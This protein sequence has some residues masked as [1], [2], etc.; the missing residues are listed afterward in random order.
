MS[1]IFFIVSKCV[2]KSILFYVIGNEK[3]NQKFKTVHHL[4]YTKT[5]LGAGPNGETVIFEVDNKNEAFA[6]QL[7]QRYEQS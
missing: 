5:V 1:P 7:K 6:N 2:S 3:T 4:P